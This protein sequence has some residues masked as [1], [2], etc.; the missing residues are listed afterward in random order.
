MLPDWEGEP[1]T[2]PYSHIV[3]ERVGQYIEVK[4]TLST[5]YLS[6]FQSR[7]NQEPD[8]R[9]LGID[10]ELGKFPLIIRSLETHIENETFDI[11]MHSTGEPL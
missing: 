5:E 7:C 1:L 11:V 2:A 8:I 10:T 9:L 3:G 6:R 4:T